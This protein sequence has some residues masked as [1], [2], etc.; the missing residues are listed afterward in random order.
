MRPNRSSWWLTLAF[1]VALACAL[2]GLFSAFVSAAMHGGVTVRIGIG[3]GS[4]PDRQPTVSGGSL[5]STTYI[6][7]LSF[8]IAWLGVAFGL[9]LVHTARKGYMRLGSMGWLLKKDER[10]WLFWTILAAISLVPVVIMTYG[11]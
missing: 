4:N 2:A 6:R 1:A 11:A 8:G 5:P 3:S 7:S 10:P 9:G